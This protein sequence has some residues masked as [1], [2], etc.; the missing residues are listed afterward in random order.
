MAGALA[1]MVANRT[2]E[3]IVHMDDVAVSVGVETPAIRPAAAAMALTVLVS[4][5][6]KVNTDL[7]LIRALARSERADPTRV[8]AI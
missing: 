6:R 1:M 2:N 8:R 4:V 7:E 5:S 3:L